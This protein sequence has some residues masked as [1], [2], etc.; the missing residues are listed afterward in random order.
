[1]GRRFV[2]EPQKLT[3]PMTPSE[4]RTKAIDGSSRGQERFH[5]KDDRVLIARDFGIMTAF[6]HACNHPAT[7]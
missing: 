3:T 1:M 4:I 7:T 5:T 6:P 2:K